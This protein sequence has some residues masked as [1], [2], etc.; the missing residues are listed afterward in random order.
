MKSYDGGGL[1]VV[2]VPNDVIPA[3]KSPRR[4]RAQLAMGRGVTLVPFAI[5][6]D[7]W[8]HKTGA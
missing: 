1:R 3:S 5:D 2:E 6:I 4:E 7:R 8:Q